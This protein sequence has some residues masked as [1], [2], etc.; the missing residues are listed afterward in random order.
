[1]MLASPV[2]LFLISHLLFPASTDRQ[3]EAYYIEIAPTV[4]IL[5]ALATTMGTLFRPI[6]FGGPLLTMDNLA[7]VPTLA[8]CLVLAATRRTR[9]HSVLVPAIVLIILLDTLLINRVLG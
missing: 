8:F 2:C 9:V 1:M 5:G 7:T 3:L 4:W 6:I